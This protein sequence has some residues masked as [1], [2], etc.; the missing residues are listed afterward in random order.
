MNLTQKLAPSILNSDFLRLGEQ[1]KSLE[2]G[3][4]DWLHFD[5][6]DGHFVPNLTFGPPMVEAIRGGTKLPLDCHLMVKEPEKFVEGFAAAGAYSITI[7]QEATANPA[8]LA[9]IIKALGCR[10]GISLKPATPLEA[11]D[12]CLAE[13]DLVLLMSVN[14]GFG[15]QKFIP[16]SLDR[17]CALRRK[18]DAAGL[19][20]DI[21]MDG[22]IG[23]SNAAEVLASGVNVLVI[24][25]S[26]FK[27]EDVAEATARFKALLK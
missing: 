2:R 23:F 11:L 18:C 10:A 9:R 8:A 21:Q 7:H 12:S 26:I 3:G 1:V 25:T 19:P 27:A 20:I 16:E 24:G 5:V 13:F 17:A 6:M 15:G 22:G 14:P 4:A